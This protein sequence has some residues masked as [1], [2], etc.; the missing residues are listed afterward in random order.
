MSIGLCGT[1]MHHAKLTVRHANTWF[2]I[3]WTCA[4][5]K[6][7]YFVT[8]QQISFF[9]SQQHSVHYTTWF[10]PNMENQKSIFTH[11]RSDQRC[12]GTK[13][14]LLQ[15]SDARYAAPS[16]NTSPY[17]N[18]PSDATPTSW[19]PSSRKNKYHK[20]ITTRTTKTKHIPSAKYNGYFILLFYI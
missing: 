1:T 18:D 15:L 5:F 3:G 11:R 10:K 6:T 20:S 17:A 12:D 13:A 16:I 2:W 19:N 14:V 7:I 4:F 8:M 9:F